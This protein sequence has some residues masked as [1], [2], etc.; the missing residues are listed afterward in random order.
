MIIFQIKA[1]PTKHITLYEKKEA[2]LL[3]VEQNANI[4]WY[5]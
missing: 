2:L 4:V 5:T 3:T 1:H